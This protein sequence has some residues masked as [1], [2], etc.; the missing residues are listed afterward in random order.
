M[1][2]DASGLPAGYPFKPDLELAPR[3]VK[4]AL[5]EGTL[6]LLDCRTK[7]EWTTARIQGATLIPLDELSQ[8][9]PEIESLAEDGA[10]IAVH[11]H[12]GSR[13]MKAALFLRQH[14]IQ[15]MSMAGGIDLWSLDIDPT[16]PRY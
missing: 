5:A 3:Q 4:A 15:A 10:A 7:G 6:V 1:K 11:C 16:V 8:R 13:S 14:G 9:L 12:H 2:L